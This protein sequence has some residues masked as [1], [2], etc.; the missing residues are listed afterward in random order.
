MASLDLSIVNVAFP[1]LERTFPRDSR[2]TLAWVI[3][4]YSIVF[5]SLLVV[6]GRTADRVGSRRVFFAGLAVFTLGSLLC[7]IAPSASS[8]WWPAGSSRVWARRPCCRR[9]WASCSAPTRPSGDR[10]WWP[11]GAASGH[12]PWPPDRRSGP[13]S[14]PGSAGGGPSSS[15]CPSDWWPGWSAVGYS[16]V[17]PGRDPG[18]AGLPRGGPARGALGRPGAGHLRGSD[19]GLDQPG[20][21]RIAGA[22]AVLAARLPRPVVA[23]RRTRARP[24]AVPVPVVQRGQSGHRALRHGLLR[25][26]ARQHPVPDQRLALLDPA[27]RAGRDPGTAGGGGRLRTGRQTGRADRLPPGAARRVRRVRLRPGLVCAAHRRA[28]RLPDG[29]AARHPGRGPRASG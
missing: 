29:V 16:R 27:G 21:H 5:G 13:C 14:S 4:G 6:A 22:A 12:W 24:A 18:H 7:G 17:A 8:C 10:R 26:A 11:C 28:P 23:P 15:T 25:H 1:A 2:A 19:L 20:R 3:T 9:R